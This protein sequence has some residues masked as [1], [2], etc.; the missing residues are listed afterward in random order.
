MK[1]VKLGAKITLSVLYTLFV[2]VN[3][4]ICFMCGPAPDATLRYL[5]SAAGLSLLLPLMLCIS[6]WI[7]VY[8]SKRIRDLENNMG[9]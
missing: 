1:W 9:G 3:M 5:V 7:N 2:A 6:L 4:F 8:L